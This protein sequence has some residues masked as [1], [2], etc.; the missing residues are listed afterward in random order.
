MIECLPTSTRRAFSNGKGA[1]KITDAH[2][3]MQQLKQCLRKEMVKTST[4]VVSKS[5]DPSSEPRTQYSR[6]VLIASSSQQLAKKGGSTDLVKALDKPVPMMDIETR[7]ESAKRKFQESCE[8]DGSYVI[9]FS[10]F[11]F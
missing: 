9:L 3:K 8:K 5:K 10:S 4:H 6:P 2:G 11:C 7:L 1:G